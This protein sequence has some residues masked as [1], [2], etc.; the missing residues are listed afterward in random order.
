MIERI[1][2]VIVLVVCFAINVIWAAECKRLNDRWRN[3]CEEMNNDWAKRCEE[4]I[5]YGEGIA[6]PL[7]RL[8]EDVRKKVEVESQEENSNG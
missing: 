6:D 7:D 1:I 4:I 2:I 3:L 8:P 5:G